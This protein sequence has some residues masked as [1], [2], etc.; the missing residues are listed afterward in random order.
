MLLDAMIEALAARGVPRVVLSTAEK[1]EG[2]QRLFEGVGFRRT[3]V[4]MTREL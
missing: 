4:E 2:A 1:N 3:M